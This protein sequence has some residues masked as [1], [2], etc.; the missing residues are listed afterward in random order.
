MNNIIELN[1]FELNDVAGGEGKC[2]KLSCRSGI[3]TDAF[4]EGYSLKSGPTYWQTLKYYVNKAVVWVTPN[5]SATSQIIEQYNTSVATYDLAYDA[6][7]M[8][9]SAR[10]M[11]NQP[12][13]RG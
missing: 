2:D 12:F 5:C 13:D 3:C 9:R 10:C 4:G 8:I 6:Y 7:S 11:A 1:S